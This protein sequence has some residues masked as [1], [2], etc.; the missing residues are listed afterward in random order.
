MLQRG[1][2]D[3]KYCISIHN[4]IGLYSGGSR[5]RGPHPPP[6]HLFLDHT[7]TR[8]AE[9]IFLENALAVLSQF[10]IQSTPDNSNLQAVRDSYQI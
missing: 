8:R 7:E 1:D 2:K 9:K 3:G 4:F 6:P 10:V 5:E